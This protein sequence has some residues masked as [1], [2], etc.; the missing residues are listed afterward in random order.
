MSIFK[1][2]TP[3]SYW[4]LIIMWSFILYFYLKRIIKRKVENKLADILIVILAID[5]FRTLFEST[6]FGLWYTSLAGMISRSIQ[7]FLVQ[8]QY[9]IIPKMLNVLAA[10]L[11]ILLLIKKWLPEEDRQKVKQRQYVDNL[12]DEVMGHKVME[13]KLSRSEAKYRN[14][15]E[16]IPQKIFYKDVNSVY[17][18]VNPSYA[19]DFGREPDDFV[20]END[21]KFYP[22]ELAQKYRDDDHSVIMTGKIKEIDEEYVVDGQTKWVHTIKNPIFDN[23]GNPIGLLGIFWDIT[24][25]KN[26]E[27]KLRSYAQVQ[28]NLL[29]EVNHRVRN[30]LTS[31][32]GMIHKE[33]RRAQNDSQ[34]DCQELLRGFASRIEGL[35]VA[36]T[37]LSRN[38]WKPLLLNEFIRELINSTINGIASSRSINIKIK[39]S[40]VLISGDQAQHLALVINE[41]VRNSVKYTKD[42]DMLDISVI[43]NK[44][45]DNIV[46]E[47]RDNGP[48]YSA[49]ILKGGKSDF[50]IGYEMLKGVVSKNMQGEIELLNDNGAVC[51]IAFKEDFFA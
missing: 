39:P 47:F 19:N 28:S 48:G 24:D 3:V 35:L 37:M 15:L 51:R 2:L 33:E 31:I 23:E 20:G 4:L 5:A 7:Q 1:L 25:R 10:F 6:Y 43:I 40:N 44:N 46:I 32:I 49:S 26:T 34:L 13:L 45:K 50:S 41:L 12:E 18:A 9:V 36:H 22:R 27:K 42:Q 14:L 17:I 11:I 21:Y 38:Q 16:N 8:P 30:N 29:S